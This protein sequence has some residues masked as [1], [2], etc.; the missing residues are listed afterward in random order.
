MLD[1]KIK[2]DLS[3]IENLQ[4]PYYEVEIK[5]DK[6]TKIVFPRAFIRGECRRKYY[7]NEETIYH[8]NNDNG[9]LLKRFDKALEAI[10]G[11]FEFYPILVDGVLYKEIREVKSN[12]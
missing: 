2:I 5:I 8:N 3:G 10:S 4:D 9:I 1:N 11:G 7:E 12:A 6:D